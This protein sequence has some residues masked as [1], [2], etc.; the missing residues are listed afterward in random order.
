[1]IYNLMYRFYKKKLESFFKS[2][3]F[4]DEQIFKQNDNKVVEIGKAPA[5]PPKNTTSGSQ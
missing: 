4:I 3:N 5:A 2:Q 1:M